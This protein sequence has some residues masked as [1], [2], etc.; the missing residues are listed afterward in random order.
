MP[1]IPYLLSQITE[2]AGLGVLL[3][4]CTLGPGILFLL[5]SSSL[6]EI[7]SPARFFWE[8]VPVTLRLLWLV[9][10]APLR[11][12]VFLSAHHHKTTPPVYTSIITTAR[13][14]AFDPV[15]DFEEIADDMEFRPASRFSYFE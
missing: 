13:A 9:V 5:V 1:D 12:I 15:S 3:L 8:W 2:L 7:G 11:L 4:G 6:Q 14:T 10:S